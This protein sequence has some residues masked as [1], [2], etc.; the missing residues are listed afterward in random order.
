MFSASEVA[1]GMKFNRYIWS[2]ETMGHYQIFYKLHDLTDTF[3]VLKLF[4]I[5]KFYL[6]CCRFNRYIWSIE[7][8][9]FCLRKLNTL[10]FNRYIWSIETSEIS[11]IN[12]SI[13]TNLT[14]TF[15]V[16]KLFE[17]IWCLDEA[18]SF[19]RYIWSIETA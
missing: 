12:S 8:F 7:T 19:N 3:G 4:Y 14:D 18:Y 9:F 2:I 1:E 13:T 16:L 10:S 5:L 15:G 17:K 6:C 11:V